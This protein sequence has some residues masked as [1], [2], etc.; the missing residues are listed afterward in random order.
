MNNSR[1]IQE[2]KTG[3]IS[4]NISKSNLSAYHWIGLP[5]IG[6]T[7]GTFRNDISLEEGGGGVLSKPILADKRGDGGQPNVGL[8]INPLIFV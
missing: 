2:D 5:S 3:I 7:N 8:S 6:G 1:N 4:D